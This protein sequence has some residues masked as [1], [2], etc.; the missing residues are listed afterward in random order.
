MMGVANLEMIWALVVVELFSVLRALREW[1]HLDMT[2]V[3]E[4]RRCTDHAFALREGFDLRREHDVA[5]ILS[6]DAASRSCGR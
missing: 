2:A 3:Y 5:S 4:N 6:P 1:V